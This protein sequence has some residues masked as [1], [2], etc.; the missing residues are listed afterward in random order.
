MPRHV[1]ARYQ[2]DGDLKDL[3]VGG[4]V[5]WQGSTYSE[6]DSS[7][8]T[9]A[10]EGSFAVVGLMARAAF[11]GHD[12]VIKLLAGHGWRVLGP[13][14]ALR[15]YDIPIMTAAFNGHLATLIKIIVTTNTSFSQ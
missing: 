6:L 2:L 7:I 10:K 15:Q 8:I 13:V 3:T 1:A 5:S 11:F 12:E 9:D 4:N 14:G